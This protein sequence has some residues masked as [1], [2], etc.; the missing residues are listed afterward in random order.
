MAVYF[1]KCGNNIKIGKSIDP[2][3]RLTSLQTGNP[4]SLEILAIAPG[5]TEFEAG[6]HIAFGDEAGRGEWFSASDKLLSFVET[7]RQTFP[8]LQEKPKQ[9]VRPVIEY[10][11]S[12]AELLEERPNKKTI[13]ELGEVHR[14]RMTHKGHFR[15]PDD[16]ERF[17]SMFSLFRWGHWLTGENEHFQAFWAKG[18]NFRFVDNQ[19]V[20]IKRVGEVSHL[21]QSYR[22]FTPLK[23][24]HDFLNQALKNAIYNRKNTADWLGVYNDDEMGIV[25]EVAKEPSGDPLP[26]DVPEEVMSYWRYYEYKKPLSEGVSIEG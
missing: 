9:F 21:P 17:P 6:L 12:G 23:S 26:L 22:E 20:L 11:S 8:H 24:L 1:I 5:G 15:Q 13:L 16:H 7:M 18:F 25:I 10:E 2:W 19:H 4:E 14:F 3:K